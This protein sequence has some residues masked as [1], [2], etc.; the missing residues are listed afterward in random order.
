MSAPVL[1][2]GISIEP[3]T[4]CEH[5]VVCLHDVNGKPMTMILMTPA[6]ADVISG[7]LA[8]AIAK[9]APD[10]LGRAASPAVN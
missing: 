9:V 10:G 2:S 4:L 3:S 7:R 1:A 5:V 6:E 8:G